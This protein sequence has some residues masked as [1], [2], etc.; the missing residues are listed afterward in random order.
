MARA[1]LLP[2]H[3]LFIFASEYRAS[4]C[5][6]LCWYRQQSTMKVTS[7][8]NGYGIRRLPARGTK[9]KTSAIA[10]DCSL[11]SI[12]DFFG[13]ISGGALKTRVKARASKSEFSLFL[14]TSSADQISCTHCSRPFCCHFCWY[15][16]KKRSRR[17]SLFPN[18][19]IEQIASKNDG[20]SANP[21][22]S[23]AT[24]SDRNSTRGVEPRQDF[25]RDRRRSLSPGHAGQ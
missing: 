25:R 13:K 23:T 16:A 12:P 10:I 22:T 6:Y 18:E 17:I 8:S 11:N 7:K 21:N 3:L 15:R 2:R 9:P 24:P 20:A 19:G 5:W 1:V 4:S 14:S